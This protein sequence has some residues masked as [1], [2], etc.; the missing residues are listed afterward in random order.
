MAMLLETLTPT[1]RA[2]FVLREVF[3]LE[4]DEIAEAVKK[5]ANAVYRTWSSWAM[6]AES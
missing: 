1:E 5:S 6:V 4:Y 3:D 2:V